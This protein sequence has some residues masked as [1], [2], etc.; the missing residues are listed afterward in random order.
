MSSGNLLQ[1]SNNSYHN[2]AA[3]PLKSHHL[4]R[5]NSHNNLD[6]PSPPLS[7]F[8][9]YSPK[10]SMLSRMHSPQMPNR[11][12]HHVR[13]S[14]DVGMPGSAVGDM[15]AAS[16][17][18]P[19]R[20]NTGPSFGTTSSTNHEYAVPN[21]FQN[22]SSTVNS[23][24]SSGKQP[25]PINGSAGG[26]SSLGNNHFHHHHSSSS[27]QQGNPAH[28]SLSSNQN[29]RSLSAGPAAANSSSG[30]S[31]NSTSSN[32]NA[33]TANTSGAPHH[34][35]HSSSD[36]ASSGAS[37]ASSFKKDDKISSKLKKVITERV[38]GKTSSDYM[39]DVG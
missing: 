29:P 17:L 39:Q 23:H 2:T 20:A 22:H 15:R 33:T 6:K 21:L 24:M 34:Y 31:P 38:T 26:A 30:V 13:M 35:H 37:R 3:S 28:S 8:V 14:I 18:V 10:R 4:S 12:H 5:G 36:K 32:S 9:G 1:A 16:P 27:S 25:A 7:T 11:S 19:S